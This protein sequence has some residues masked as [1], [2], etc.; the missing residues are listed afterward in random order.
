VKAAVVH[1]YGGPDELKYEDVPDPVA[2]PGEVL[3][4]V[5]ATAINPVDLLEISG[6]M[7][8]RR[9]LH[10][11]AILGR[12]VSG[13]VVALGAGVQNLKIGDKVCAWILHTFAELCAADAGLFAKLPDGLDIVDAAALPLV[14][15]TGSEL[16]SV[17][18]NV[19][20]GDTV[21]V[22]GAA[23][24][25]GRSAVFTAKKLGARVFAGVLK[26]QLDQAESIGA[27][28]A[29]A[30]DDD[31]AFAALPQA[32]VVANTVRGKTATL[33][34]GKVKPNGI[35]ASV[36]GAPEN[37]A[38]SQVNVVAFVSKQDT[39][40]LE[41]LL[42]AARDDKLTIPIDRRIPLRDAA[43]GAAAVAKGGIGKVL[44]TP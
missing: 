6:A 10:F 42:E 26:D 7:K 39:P 23:G 37:A 11:P 3:V 20:A 1:E 2:G 4:K 38:G 40:L 34:L 36:T 17:A 25:V 43:A 15:L 31:E 41:S 5:A 21:I 14:T 12:D 44:L 19:S 24:G 32:D 35:F 18:G 16:V 28:E 13:T 8:D 29:I 22:A 30:L 9:P 33:L 27:D